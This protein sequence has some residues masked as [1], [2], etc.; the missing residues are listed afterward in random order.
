MPE[1]AGNALRAAVHLAVEHH[2]GRQESGFAPTVVQEELR[3]GCILV[4]VMR[5][6]TEP[7]CLV[8]L[9][10]GGRKVLNDV[11]KRGELLVGYP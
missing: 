3:V 1:L 5:P 11:L 10:K 2:P 7:Q 8:D 9:L 4:I 6:A